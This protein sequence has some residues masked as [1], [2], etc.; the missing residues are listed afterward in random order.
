[1]QLTVV[2]L[3]RR[4]ARLLPGTVFWLASAL[5][6]VG[7]ESPPQEPV[8]HISL[9]DGDLTLVSEGAALETILR[10]LAW[11]GQFEIHIPAKLARRA[12]TISLDAVPLDAALRR[13]L[14][15]TSFLV[16]H[17]VPADTGERR[18]TEVR[19]LSTGGPDSRALATAPLQPGQR[20]LVSREAGAASLDESQRSTLR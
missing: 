15:G 19:I 18:L 6:V 3:A 8:L 7:A 14:E 16:M 17:D 4:A 20:E 10:E 12:I 9:R 13:L 1:M 2:T 11:Q 5:C